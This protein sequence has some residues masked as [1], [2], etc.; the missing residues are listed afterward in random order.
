MPRE[1]DVNRGVS[2]WRYPKG[3]MDVFMYKNEPGIYLDA[4]GREVPEKLAKAA[5]APV[6]KYRKRRMIKEEQ[7]RVTE[8]LKEKYELDA[9]EV[10]KEVDGLQL[11]EL[12]GGMMRVSRVVEGETEHLSQPIA[13]EFAKELFEDMSGVKVE[14]DDGPKDDGLQEAQEG[15]KEVNDGEEPS[16]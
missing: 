10:V 1:I 14:E 4:H 5:G 13:P 6:E 2:I 12:P 15:G 11:I 9:P 16:A 7:A 3:G 8:A